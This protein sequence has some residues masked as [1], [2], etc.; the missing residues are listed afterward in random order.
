MDRINTATKAEDLFGAGKHG[1]K[2]S[3]ASLGIVATDFNADWPNGVQEELL[4][5]IEGAGIVPDVATRTQVRQAVKRLFGGN[6][7][8][9]NAANSPFALTADHAGLVI[10]DATAG[11]IVVNLPAANLLSALIFKFVRNDVT[12][13]TATVNCAGADTFVGGATS[14]TLI[15]QGDARHIHGDAVSKW[16]SSLSLA[17]NAEAQALS[18]TVKAISPATLAQAFKAANQSL[19]PSGYQK[20]PGGLIVQWGV[21]T[22][23][24]SADTSITFPVAFTTAAYAVVLNQQNAAGGAGYLAVNGFGLTSFLGNGWTG[25]STRAA[26]YGSWM[27]IGY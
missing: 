7:T 23:S 11:N 18:S 20:L 27:A 22:T 10:M 16:A 3:N 12:T 5:I 14:F 6:V 21:I 13:N 1:W 15:G 25:S 19:V 4:S 8:T 9:V 26:L 24:A 17:S 2:N